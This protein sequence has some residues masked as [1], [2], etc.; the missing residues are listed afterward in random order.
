LFYLVGEDPYQFSV[1]GIP[2]KVSDGFLAGTLALHDH[3]V[4]LIDLE[5]HY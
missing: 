5:Q 3:P 1:E 2:N 4:E